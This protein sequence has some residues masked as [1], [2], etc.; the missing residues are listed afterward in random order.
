MDRYARALKASEPQW[1]PEAPLA[2]RLGEL[3]IADPRVR[4]L[5]DETKSI[6]KALGGDTLGFWLFEQLPSVST[7]EKICGRS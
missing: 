7:P 5:A 4:L 1:L 6:A 3:R 2:T